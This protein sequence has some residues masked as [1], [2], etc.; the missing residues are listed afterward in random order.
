MYGLVKEWSEAPLCLCA[1]NECMYSFCG[2][3][4]FVMQM[5]FSVDILKTKVVD[6]FLIFLVLK[7]HDFRPA[8]LGV[9]DFTNLLSAFACALN[10]SALLYYLAYLNMESC[11]GDNRRVVVLFLRF[12]KCLRSLFLVV[13]NSS[14][15]YSK[16]NGRFC[17]NLDRDAFIGLFSLLSCRII[18]W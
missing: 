18:L 12:L 2:S 3:D 4:I 10:R 1:E 11:I 9:I 15:C 13:Y 5:M 8:G 14:Y 7:F 16:W 6:N 17:P